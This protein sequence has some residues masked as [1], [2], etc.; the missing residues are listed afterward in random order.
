MNTHLISS[1]NPLVEKIS[2]HSHFIPASR[3]SWSLFALLSLHKK[4]EKQVIAMPSFICQSVVAAAA[5]AEWEIKF[6]DIDCNSGMVHYQNYLSSYADDVDA[7]LF[8]HLLG[9]QNKLGNLKKF[10][11]QAEILLIEDSAQ[12]YPP[13]E[14]LENNDDLSHARLISFGSTKLIDMNQGGLI[15]SDDKS[16]LSELTSFQKKFNFK[17]K[18]EIKPSLDAFM[19][20][21]YS[22]KSDLVKNKNIKEGLKKLLP[23]YTPAISLEV[24]YTQDLISGISDGIMNLSSEVQLRQ[25]NMAKYEDAFAGSKLIA[26]SDHCSVPWRASF[27]IEGLTYKSQHQL[28]EYIRSKGYDVSNWYLPAHWYFDTDDSYDAG[29]PNTLKLSQEIIQFWVNKKYDKHH[30]INLRNLIDKSM[31]H[32]K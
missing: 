13:K 12:F 30:F 20:S 17:K 5:L 29:L 1:F 32:E 28:S 4:K 2:R 18:L 10:C 7:L 24:N 14:S 21:F 23:I 15:L 8:V 9:N 27:R 11:D 31:D 6:L 16:L 25:L 26:V 22:L 3:A 19:K